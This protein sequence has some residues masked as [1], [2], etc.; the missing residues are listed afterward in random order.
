M[1]KIFVLILCLGLCGCAS[2]GV[3]PADKNAYMISKR[4]SELSMGYPIGTKTAVYREANAFCAK[5][6]KKVETVACNVENTVPFRPGSV[7]LEFRCVSDSDNTS[8]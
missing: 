7:S 6:N 5:Q 2:T 8:K 1:K 3:V 4:S